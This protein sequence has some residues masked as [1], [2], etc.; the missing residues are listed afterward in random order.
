MKVVDYPDTLE[1]MVLACM[2]L[3]RKAMYYKEVFLNL[4]ETVPGKFFFHQ[5]EGPVTTDLLVSTFPIFV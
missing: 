5:D 2:R 3:T 4:C 1:I